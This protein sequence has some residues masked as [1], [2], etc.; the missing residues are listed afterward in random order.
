MQ[1]GINETF[2]RYEELD[3]L[4]IEIKLISGYDLGELKAMLLAGWR[5][6]PPKDLMTEAESFEALLKKGE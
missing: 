5:L 2:S 1:L 3:K 6:M 4:A